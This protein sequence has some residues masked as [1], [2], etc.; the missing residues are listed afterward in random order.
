MTTFLTTS[1]VIFIFS[2]FKL[3]PN[4]TEPNNRRLI[5]RPGLLTVWNCQ[6]NATKKFRPFKSFKNILLAVLDGIGFR[7]VSWFL[8]AVCLKKDIYS[9]NYSQTWFICLP[10]RY[11]CTVGDFGT[12][13]LLDKFGPQK[14]T[15]VWHTGLRDEE[16]GSRLI[17]TTQWDSHPHDNFHFWHLCEPSTAVILDNN[18]TC[19]SEKK[20]IK[21]FST[22]AYYTHK[23]WY[24]QKYFRNRSDVP[25]KYMC[26]PIP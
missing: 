26:V 1:S 13:E 18:H 2:Q 17:D 5:Y 14:H 21:L 15:L 20:T 7:L 25:E 23:Y 11:C 24:A 22:I 10:I 19:K 8:L 4:H 6:L 3:W 9:K 12:L 16:F